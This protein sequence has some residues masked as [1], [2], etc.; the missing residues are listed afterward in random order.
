[1]SKVTVYTFEKDESRGKITAGR[2]VYD[3]N[4]PAA[5]TDLTREGAIIALHEIA[6]WHGHNFKSMTAQQP[7][8]FTIRVYRNDNGQVTKVDMPGCF[9]EDQYY[10]VVR[11]LADW[12]GLKDSPMPPPL[13]KEWKG[14]PT[15][16]MA[17]MV[18]AQKEGFAWD[19][20]KQREVQPYHESR[21]IVSENTKPQVD[22]ATAVR[23]IEDAFREDKEYRRSWEAN[24]AV[25]VKDEINKLYGEHPLSTIPSHTQIMGVVDK[26]VSN[27]F[28]M[29]LHEPTTDLMWTQ[30]LDWLRRGKKIKLPEWTGY[31]FLEGDFIKVLTGDG[32]VLDTPHQ[33]FQKRKDW[34]VTDGSLGFDWALRAMKN[35]KRVKRKSWEHSTDAMILHGNVML[36]GTNGVP[37]QPSEE[38]MNGCILA[39]DWMLYENHPD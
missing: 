16:P 30:A 39:T 27:F 9:R 25:N 28:D 17:D 12:F 38:L 18:Q 8:N 13:T 36:V 6:E 29:L 14:T 20:E 35:G 11:D 31:W 23:I 32:D 7:T 37:F 26:G 2:V 21:T 34:Q 24:I 22:L 15:I 5:T 1:M 3:R 10:N 33:H 19:F 4:K